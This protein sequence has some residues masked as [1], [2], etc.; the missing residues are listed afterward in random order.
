MA[1]V[2]PKPEAAAEGTAVVPVSTKSTGLAALAAKPAFLQDLAPTG[3]EILNRY[4][5]PPRLKVV[6]KTA[7]PPYDQFSTGD[8]LCMPDMAVVGAM[9]FDDKHKP[10]KQ[11]SPFY[12]VP[13]FF[14]P[15]WLLINPIEAAGTLP[16]IEERTLDPRSPLAKR[17]QSPSTRSE[18]CPQMPR[19]GNGKELY[20]RYVECLN[21]CVV[22]LGDSEFCGKPTVMS[23]SR[24]S[25][26]LAT[27]FGGLLRGRKAPM[28]SCVFECRSTFDSNEKGDWYGIVPANPSEASGVSPWV[29]S[30]ADMLVFKEAG[31]ELRQA[32]KDSVI[33]VD[34]ADLDELHEAG[35]ARGGDGGGKF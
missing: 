7:R 33:D 13:V 8:V 11:G 10:H 28:E 27:D 16:M 5:R 12:V 25:Y 31:D 29:E 9:T 17:S 21:Y 35:Q 22:I 32:H 15:E 4:I 26:Y 19:D 18:I 20:R 1:K 24:G 34:Y 23:Y 6:Q 30:E 14:F 2:G 3:M